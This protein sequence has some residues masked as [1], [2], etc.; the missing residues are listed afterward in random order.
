MDLD[1]HLSV[2]DRRRS[3]VDVFQ[4]GQWVAE[5]NVLF[6]R[7]RDIPIPRRLVPSLIR[8]LCPR[9]FAKIHRKLDA[10]FRQRRHGA[11]VDVDFHMSVTD[12]GRSLVD[13]FR[14]G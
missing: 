6:V 3:Q 7:K 5:T 9:Q 10:M 2:T 11:I 1:S 4:G 13:K 14:G 12:R 8:S